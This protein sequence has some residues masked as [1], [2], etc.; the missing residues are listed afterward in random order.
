MTCTTPVHPPGMNKMSVLFVLKNFSTSSCLQKM[1]LQGAVEGKDAPV[2]SKQV[3][4]DTCFFPVLE[5]LGDMAQE[6]LP[7]LPP[8]ACGVGLCVQRKVT[9][10]PAHESHLHGRLPLPQWSEPLALP[11]PP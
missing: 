7:S 3:V 9:D 10:C 2:G 11:P 6:S 1:V 5:E 8:I 4:D